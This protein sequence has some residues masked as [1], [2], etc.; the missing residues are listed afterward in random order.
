MNLIE[1]LRLPATVLLVLAAVLL[2]FC[3]LQLLTLRRRLDAG[4]RLAAG[5][6][7][8]LC[9]VCLVLSLLL[10]VGGWALRGYRLLDEETPVVEIDAHILSPQ[11]WAVTL[12]WPDGA[13]RQVQLAGDDWRV[14]AVVLKWKLL[15][16]LPPLYRLDRIDGRY[17]DATQEQSAPRTVV[18]LGFADGFD[19]LDLHRQYPRALPMVD[20]VYGSGAFLPLVDGGHYSLS[21]SG[22]GALV[23]RPDAATERRIGSPLGGL[24]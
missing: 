22:A 24:R 12:T 17:D 9:V 21:L 18:A 2:L 11:R 19:L 15:V 8:L 1:L 20:A 6:H 4:A 16:G 13:T 10:G 3:L 5:W 23:A 14:E 7:G